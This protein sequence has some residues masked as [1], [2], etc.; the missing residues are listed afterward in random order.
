VYTGQLK[1]SCTLHRAQQARAEP[2]PTL[3][4]QTE[5]A[6]DTKRVAW[7]CPRG[8]NNP[9]W[10]CTDVVR[11][12]QPSVR[13][14]GCHSR[15]THAHSACQHQEVLMSLQTAGAAHLLA[16]PPSG[17]CTTCFPTSNSGPGHMERE[18]KREP[19]PPTATQLKAPPTSW[20]QPQSHRQSV[21]LLLVTH[22][23][24][25]MPRQC[26]KN[27][28]QT[29]APKNRRKTHQYIRQQRHPHPYNNPYCI[30]LC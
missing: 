8:Q 28:P 23:T 20:C 17:Q 24:R 16:W 27:P 3:R 15:A 26:R 2:L 5:H 25:P 30:K 6:Q 7:V 9:W 13:L 10:S 1:P 14:G 18:S 11:H 21:L 29:Q 19:G 12:P 22:N 4:H